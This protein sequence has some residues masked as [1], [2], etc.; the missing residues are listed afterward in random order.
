MAKKQTVA[1]LK[2]SLKRIF[3]EYIRLRDSDENGFC[4]CIS[5]GRKHYWRGVKHLGIKPVMQMGHFI[6]QKGHPS[7]MFNPFNAHAQCSYCNGFLQGNQ[8]LYGK[9]L[10]K[11]YG[12]KIVDD[13]FAK[14]KDEF[15]FTKD[16]LHRNIT[17]YKKEV[18]R[19]KKSKKLINI[20]KKK[21]NASKAA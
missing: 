5:C 13:L 11:M 6:Q 19:L 1:S 8:Y 17:Y 15:I 9:K 20:P 14:S 4:T 3:S 10:E 7:I 21:N 12:K 16:W 18:D 2:R